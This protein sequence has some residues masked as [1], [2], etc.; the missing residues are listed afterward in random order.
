MNVPRNPNTANATMPTLYARRTSSLAT[1]TRAS[2][3]TPIQRTIGEKTYTKP[4]IS[5]QMQRPGVAAS[6]T[7]LAVTGVV[8]CG[9]RAG[10]PG[11]HQA[12]DPGAGNLP[13]GGLLA[14]GTTKGWSGAG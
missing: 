4:P 8:G 9:C 3:P 10:G 13:G 12:G 2:R 5:R 6:R 7:A 14:G 11:P 1:L